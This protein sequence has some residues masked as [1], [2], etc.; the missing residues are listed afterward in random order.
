MTKEEKDKYVEKVL[1]ELASHDEHEKKQV[2]PCIY[3]TT[4]NVR[5]GQGTL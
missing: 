4:C 3:C 5:L 1:A 2:G